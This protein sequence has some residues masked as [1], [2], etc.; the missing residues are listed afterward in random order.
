MTVR[1]RQGLYRE[2]WRGQTVTRRRR[3]SCPDSATPAPPGI[4]ASAACSRAAASAGI[5]PFALAL[6]SMR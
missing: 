2:Q 6:N 1:Q 3:R 5:D 4:A